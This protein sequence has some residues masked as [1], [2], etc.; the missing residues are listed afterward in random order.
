MQVID[1]KNSGTV[2]FHALNSDLAPDSF[3]DTPDHSVF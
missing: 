2:K 3:A 1:M